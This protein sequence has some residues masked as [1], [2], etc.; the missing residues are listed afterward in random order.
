MTIASN[1]NTQ[2]QLDTV[3]HGDCIDVMGRMETA[4]VDMILSGPPYITLPVA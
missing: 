1:R 2:Q 3:I 4:S